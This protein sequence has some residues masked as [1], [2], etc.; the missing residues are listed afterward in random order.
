[1]EAKSRSKTIK[2]Y[3]A[4]LLLGMIAGGAVV[5]IWQGKLIESLM[6]QNQYKSAEI[7]RLNEVIEDMKQLQKVAKKK[8]EPIIEEV[9]VFVLPPRPHEFI[10][11][12]AIRLIEK[13]L[14][15]LKGMKSR[16]VADLHA[17]LHEL[18]YR[19]EYL[20]DGKTVEVRLKTA[21]ISSVLEVYVTIEL[22]PEVP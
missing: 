5:L 20:V 1:M 22:K 2:R 19:R 3:L 7:V 6:K 21:Y 15:P 13:E 18:L 11:T 16:T 4:L 10:E 12:A 14:D 9:K 17:I 8:Q